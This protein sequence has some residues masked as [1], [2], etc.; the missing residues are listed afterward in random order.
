MSEDQDVARSLAKQKFA[1][2]RRRDKNVEP[3]NKKSKQEKKTREIRFEFKH[4]QYIKDSLCFLPFTDPIT[5]EA[6]FYSAW[7]Q[8][9]SYYFFFPLIIAR[10]EGKGK[11]GGLKGINW[12]VGSD[13]PK[14]IFTVLRLAF[15]RFYPSLVGDHADWEIWKWNA[16]YY[17]KNLAESAYKMDDLKKRNRLLKCFGG[18]KTIPVISPV[19]SW[20]SNSKKTYAV[21]LEVYYKGDVDK[22]T[23][24]VT[25]LEEIFSAAEKFLVD[26]EFI[27]ASEAKK[28]IDSNPVP[29][30]SDSSSQESESDTDPNP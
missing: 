2:K 3:K 10:P 1:R 25:E 29:M 30:D 28:K 12:T 8:Q 22:I 17:G 27:K 16:M 20:S 7:S 5:G 9:P 11:K 15:E 18:S 19:T 26:P 23:R 14:I 6:G 24:N 21:P 4:L 13:D